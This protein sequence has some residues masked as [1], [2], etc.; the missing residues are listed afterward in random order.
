MG[1]ANWLR[2]LFKGGG[3]EVDSAS[4][5]IYVRCSSC[6]EKL[7]LRINRQSEL[8][9]DFGRGG[10]Y[11]RKVAVGQ[12]CFRQIE[13]QLQLDDDYRQ[14]SCDVAGGELL[15]REQYEASSTK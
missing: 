10:Y 1:V 3:E 8:S 4:F 12:R 15:T 2:G 13:I 14:V 11:L 6:G 7:R 5:Y 9:R